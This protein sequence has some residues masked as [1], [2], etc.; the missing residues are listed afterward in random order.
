MALRHSRL[1]LPQPAYSQNRVNAPA[2]GF[3]SARVWIGSAP[4]NHP[5]DVT[6]QPDELI[7]QMLA[8]ETL[9]EDTAADLRRMLEEFRAGNLHP[10]DSEYI[11]ALHAKLAG[12]LPED[13]AI[14]PAPTEEARLDGLTI[15]EWRER[16]LAAEAERDDLREALPTV[17]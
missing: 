5:G 1:A 4:T 7:Q 17:G 9:N 8:S 13:G 14:A 15:G 11:V 2:T 16:A 12:T 6:V 10:D 3:L